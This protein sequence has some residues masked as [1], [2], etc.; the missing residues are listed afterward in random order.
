MQTLY[1]QLGRW[2]LRFM[3][4][5]VARTSTA[6][7]EPMRFIIALHPLPYAAAPDLSCRQSWLSHPFSDVV[8]QDEDTQVE[9]NWQSPEFDDWSI[10]ASTL[11]LY[12]R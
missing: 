8:R 5:V 1:V 6:P 3:M 4:C 9:L 2:R 11:S 10:V 12:L 7:H